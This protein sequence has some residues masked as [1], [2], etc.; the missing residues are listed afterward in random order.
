[1]RADETEQRTTTKPDSGGVVALTN[2][3]DG[4][5]CRRDEMP[6]KPKGASVRRSD[7]QA[8]PSTARCR[9]NWLPA[10]AIVAHGRT[11]TRAGS[12]G[13]KDNMKGVTAQYACPRRSDNVVAA[14]L[15]HR[16]HPPCRLPA[17]VRSPPSPTLTHRSDDPASPQRLVRNFRTPS[18]G[19]CGRSLRSRPRRR[20]A[21]WVLHPVLEV[22]SHRTLRR[23]RYR[24]V[25]GDW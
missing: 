11:I 14:H 12:D 18:R 22:H 23:G 24:W 16:T 8:S 1:M 20:A 5:A 19:A 3:R 7:E 15:G 10:A 13:R 25:I 2:R 4:Q 9:L 21:N 17:A 6:T